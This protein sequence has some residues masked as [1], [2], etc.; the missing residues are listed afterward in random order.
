MSI[1]IS[2]QNMV[3]SFETAIE[4]LEHTMS[5]SK[6]IHE[7]VDF[8]SK[9]LYFINYPWIDDNK[10]RVFYTLTNYIR[11][12]QDSSY[13]KNDLFELLRIIFI[14]LYNIHVQFN[15]NYNDFKNYKIIKTFTREIMVQLVKC[16]NAF[17]IFKDD[18]YSNF[19][20]LVDY[21]D[22]NG[23][24][25]KCG[26][27]GNI[28]ALEK[29]YFTDNI[30]I[31]KTNCTK[32]LDN[33]L[34]NNDDRVYKYIVKLIFDENIDMSKIL[35]P[36]YWMSIISNKPKSD[37]YKLKKLKYLDNHFD[38]S[39]CTNQIFSQFSV[40]STKTID[41][42]LKY[43]LNRSN[44]PNEILD[45]ITDN[46]ISYYYHKLLLDF[47]GHTDEE[48][49][50]MHIILVKYFSK[51][52]VY[53]RH[54]QDILYQI[55]HGTD[56]IILEKLLYLYKHYS[57]K[58]NIRINDIKT[59]SK[60]I[61][62]VLINNKYNYNKLMLKIDKL[63]FLFSTFNKSI[64]NELFSSS[65]S[66]Y[67]STQYNQAAYVFLPYIKPF[68]L[69]TFVKKADGINLCNEYHLLRLN[70][71][72]HILKIFIRKRVKLRKFYKLISSKNREVKFNLT[73][74]IK[75]YNFNQP[76]Y[77]LLPYEL[78]KI[79]TP[80]LIKEK[81]D[82]IL[83]NELPKSINIG[84]EKIK[85]EYIE[86]LDLY[87]VFDIDLPDYVSIEARY[88][89][90]RNLH[91]FIKGKY[92]EL[93]TI[94][95]F[96]DFKDKINDERNLLVEFI[97]S[98]NGV[99]W[100][101]KCSWKLN[102]IS[103]MLPH[104]LDIINDTNDELY[105]WIC[106]DFIYKNDGLIIT[107]LNQ[108]REIKLKPKRLM[109]ID[110]L[111]KNK[112]FY[113]REGNL[114]SNIL[115]NDTSLELDDNTIWRC[116]PSKCN[117][118]FYP[119]DFRYDKKKP[120]PRSVVL[121]ITKLVTVTYV[122]DMLNPIYYNSGFIRN[123]STPTWSKI[124]KTS[125]SYIKNIIDKYKINKNDIILDLGCG[126]NKFNKFVK[127]NCYYGVDYDINLL[128]KKNNKSNKEIYNYM[129][130]GKDWCNQP[131]WTYI[132]KSISYDYI[133][134]INSLM[135]F[136]TEIF[137]KQINKILVSGKTKFIFNIVNDNANTRYDFDNSFIFKSN[138]SVYYYFE[139][140]HSHIKKERF[141]TE[142]EILMYINKY[143][144]HIS[145]KWTPDPAQS[146]LHSKYTWYVISK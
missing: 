26:S 66:Y 142:K 88:M 124:V 46:N 83:V 7:V 122:D 29:I 102:N 19:I 48:L 71:V 78:Q 9:N 1:V 22:I 41:L 79:D 10:Y 54:V 99:K 58:D 13:E 73:D 117:K 57:L 77:H 123:G 63:H 30:M 64:I 82:G 100:W 112:K 90:L 33:A 108:N 39:S 138:D 119:V 36:S 118:Y 60:E 84:P 40:S 126:K 65:K 50:P 141:I 136:S 6:D 86:E 35:I 116:Y 93:A 111:V 127:F 95:T 140:I 98:T 144:L 85:A 27:F 115:I 145:N 45:I 81:A 133:F 87:L 56:P 132:D 107:P 97:R 8:M 32:V 134:A 43:Y 59:T 16:K 114:Y 61:I 75:H 55:M 34:I 137:W 47:D 143:K 74:N 2:E 31:N 70:R 92:R 128:L 21:L 23:N 130:L 38:I 52:D 96:E 14:D 125:E 109:T 11:C 105:K 67:D 103:V 12:F 62:G 104:L 135:H 69:K 20:R 49:S 94:T 68:L 120:N 76:P 15:I 25:I 4:S 44:N 101:P 24:L 28:K 72:L 121:N 3:N 89:Y 110:L 131:S 139:H 129:D 37:M 106:T 18:G 53:K 91:P 80:I 42:L 5:T 17:T 146:E 113:D 51:K